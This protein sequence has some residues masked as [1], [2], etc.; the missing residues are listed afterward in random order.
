M[1]FLIVTYL[2]GM[3]ITSHYSSTDHEKKFHDEP[4]SHKILKKQIVGDHMVRK[5]TFYIQKS[6]KVF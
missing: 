4:V 2:H 3:K 1:P 6:S 5:L